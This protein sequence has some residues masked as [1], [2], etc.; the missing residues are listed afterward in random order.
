MTRPSDFTD[1]SDYVYLKNSGQTTLT[2]TIPSGTSIN[3]LST[4]LLKSQTYSLASTEGN[5]PR[6]L[7][8]TS[9]ATGR[10]I[11]G[12]N[13]IFDVNCRLVMTYSGGG[14]TVTD[15]FPLSIYYRRVSATQVA[16]YATTEGFS[17][18]TTAQLTTLEAV[19]ITLKLNYFRTL[20]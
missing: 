15:R 18:L 2:F 19:T 10:W 16:I 7:W 13:P 20:W 12:N 11:P 6:L 5:I 17:G 1:N 9:K 4:N 14:E 8:Q 3:V